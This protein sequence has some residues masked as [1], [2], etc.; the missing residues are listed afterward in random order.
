MKLRHS[1][2]IV[3]PNSAIGDFNTGNNDH[4]YQSKVT[5]LCYSPDNS[6]LAVA[7][8]DR[9]IS[10]YN[11]QGERVDKFNTKANSNGSK[12]Y[13]I[14]SIQFGPD[15]DHPKLA[16]AQSDAIVFVYKWKRKGDVN[17]QGMEND[18][19]YGTT[20][21]ESKWDGKKSICNKF[22]ET[23][24]V[25]SLLWSTKHPFQVV[26][27]LVEGK[28]K[29]GNLRTN[30][31]KTLYKIESNIV[32]SLVTNLDGS[33]LLSGHADGSIY[34]FVFPTK[35]KGS[36]CIKIIDSSSTVPYALSWGRS[37]CVAGLNDRVVFF[38]DNGHKEQ[39]FSYNDQ[40]GLISSEQFVSSEFTTSSCSPNGD[41]IVIGSFDCFYLFVWNSTNRSWE[42]SVT[43]LIKNMYSVTAIGWKPDGSSVVLGTSSGVVD[44]YDAAY[45]QFIY[46]DAFLVTYVS[47]SQILV[48][49]KDGMN[50]CPVLI[51]SSRGEITKLKIYHD[52]GTSIYRYIVARTENSLIL[53]DMESPN[54]STSEVSWR[55]DD[56]L[57]EKF[58][59]D[60]S[61]ACIIRNAGELSVVEVSFM[62]IAQSKFGCINT[63]PISFLLSLSCVTV[64]TR[65]NSRLFQNRV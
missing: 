15:V 7:T 25:I 39:S 34:R 53:C 22:P 14:R 38:D 52:P 65:R 8:A 58:I 57:K 60:A 13:L 41:S 40:D 45:R 23:S 31:S 11:N 1:Q 24:A 50:S 20:S 43:H 5:S 42:E 63:R 3:V 18:K 4:V 36:S 21:N 16:I 54:N 9:V 48:R 61:N 30:K 32:L 62:V 49:D 59:F 55:Y 35:T 51:Q 44:E 37:I 47:P 26:Y 27:G 56:K 33:E 46:R 19:G 10:I 12:D 28:I 64:R 29:I 2:S 6:R 17:R